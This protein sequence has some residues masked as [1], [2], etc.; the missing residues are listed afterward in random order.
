VTSIRGAA[1]CSLRNGKGGRRREIG[2]DAWAF[3][4]LRPWLTARVELLEAKLG[5]RTAGDAVARAL[6]ESQ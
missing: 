3:E 2:M 6:H 1:H 4:Q 5:V